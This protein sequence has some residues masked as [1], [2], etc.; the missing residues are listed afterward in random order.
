MPVILPA[1]PTR[2]KVVPEDGSSANADNVKTK[3]KPSGEEFKKKQDNTLTQPVLDNLNAQMQYVGA[4]MINGVIG[5]TVFRVGTRYVMTASHVIRPVVYD[6]VSKVLDLQRLRSEHIY[7]NFNEAIGIL[8]RVVCYLNCCFYHEELDVAVLEL[9][10]LSGL[11]GKMLLCKGD[12]NLEIENVSVIGYGNPKQQFKKHLDPLCEV[13][14]QHGREIRLAHRYLRKNKKKMKKMLSN[15]KTVDDG[16]QGYDDE[17]NII[18]HGF[19]E[20]GASGGPL[21]VCNDPHSVKVIGVLT[22]GIPECFYNLPDNEQNKFPKNFRFHL[23]CRMP[24]I[25]NAIYAENEALA[26]DLFGGH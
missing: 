20:H 19:L 6:G 1:S 23:A 26:K 17:K 8:P 7:V 16:Y 2:E 3:T 25:Y 22:H 13:V 24:M 11:P 5:G 15:P 9:S 10:N 18:F 12:T 14:P 4:L 21:L